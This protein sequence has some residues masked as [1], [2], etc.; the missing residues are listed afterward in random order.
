[1]GIF[2]KSLKKFILIILKLEKR[3]EI[4][5]QTFRKLNNSKKIGRK[6]SA[7][8]FS[9][10]KKKNRKS[11]ERHIRVLWKWPTWQL[12]HQLHTP[13]R[14]VIVDFFFF[15]SVPC[16]FFSSFWWRYF[17]AR[18]VNEVSRP[19]SKQVV[20]YIQL[21]FATPLAIQVLNISLEALLS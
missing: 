11:D 19:A 17:M 2:W 18:S 5:I 9:R 14:V 1:M 7:L 21:H 16:Y 3:T 13:A 20:T 15:G 10:K 8:A 6:E 4:C 12:I